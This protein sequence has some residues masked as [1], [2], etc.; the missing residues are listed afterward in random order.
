MLSRVV[1]ST[2]IEIHIDADSSGFN[3]ISTRQ[4]FDLFNLSTLRLKP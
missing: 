1:E 2:S 3:H 4:G